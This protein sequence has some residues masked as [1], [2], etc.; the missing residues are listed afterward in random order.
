M[1]ILGISIA[2]HGHRR[3]CCT[4]DCLQDRTGKGSLER[5]RR[6]VER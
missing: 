4:L 6:K 5:D 3:W 2:T 1:G